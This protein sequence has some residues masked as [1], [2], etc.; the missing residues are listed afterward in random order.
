MSKQKAKGTS[1]ETSVL[2]L[3]RL[4]YPQ[5]TRAPL[6]GKNDVGDLNLPT[7]W[8]Y[9]CELKNHARL[10]LAGWLKEA[11]R[12]AANK[13]PGV[14]GVVVHKRR[15][16]TNPAEQYVTLTLGDFLY[17]VNGDP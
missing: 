13:G 17:L 15:G 7:E 9:I 3:F 16:T 2:P 6:V 4:Y 12:E 5:A 14:A 11:Q 10:D 1:F 8:R